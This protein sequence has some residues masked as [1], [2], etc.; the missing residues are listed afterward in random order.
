MTATMTAPLTVKYDWATRDY[1]WFDADSPDERRPILRNAYI[2]NIVRVIL[3][4]WDYLQDPERTGLAIDGRPTTTTEA[5]TELYVDVCVAI[6]E[7]LSDADV[8]K[9]LDFYA[10]EQTLKTIATQYGIVYLSAKPTLESMLIAVTSYLINE[11]GWNTLF[12][13]PNESTS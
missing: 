5:L 11:R 7:C 13:T 10:Y 4:H 3:Q 1:Y 9:F 6:E 2:E 12:P 8:P